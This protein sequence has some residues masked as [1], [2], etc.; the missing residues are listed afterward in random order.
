MLPLQIAARTSWRPLPFDPAFR[1]DAPSCPRA[2]VARRGWDEI[3]D[4]T[5]TGSWPLTLSHPLPTKALSPL[6]NETADDS[7]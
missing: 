5:G 2:R 7:A 6:S 3:D 4:W 1:S